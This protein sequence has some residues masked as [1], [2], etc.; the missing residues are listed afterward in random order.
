MKTKSYTLREI[1]KVTLI[2]KF[3]YSLINDDDQ[4]LWFVGYFV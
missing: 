1:E 2:I 4:T 3:A